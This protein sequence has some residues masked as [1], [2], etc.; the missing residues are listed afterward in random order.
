MMNTGFISS[1]GA[2]QEVITFMAAPLQKTTADVVAGV[3]MPF[4]QMFVHPPS[5]NF[6]EHHNVMH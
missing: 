5:W 6:A 2:I 3:L 1:D 4:C